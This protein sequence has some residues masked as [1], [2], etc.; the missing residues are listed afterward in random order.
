MSEANDNEFDPEREGEKE[1]VD[2]AAIEREFIDEYGAAND[3]KRKINRQVQL[4]KQSLKNEIV[5]PVILPF[6][7]EAVKEI[8]ALIDSQEEELEQEKKSSN[9]ALRQTI[10]QMEIDRVKYVLVE[11]LRV[12]LFKIQ[13]YALYTLKHPDYVSRLSENETEFAKDFLKL[14]FDHTKQT[15]LEKLPRVFQDFQEQNGQVDMVSKPNLDTF[16]FCRVAEDVGDVQL[17]EDDPQEVAS[18][19]RGDLV[20]IPF[21][22]IS[23]LVLNGDVMLM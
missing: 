20:A 12:R 1:T 14:E 4:L 6:E 23:D 11:Y 18:M 8:K 19:N 2:E 15:F 21:R 5:S 22:T 3:D 10:S 9:I 13:K 16:V 17:V 7:E